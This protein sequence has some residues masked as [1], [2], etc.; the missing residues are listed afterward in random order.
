MTGDQSSDLAKIAREAKRDRK[1]LGI[2]GLGISPL[3]LTDEV[4]LSVSNSFSGAC[5]VVNDIDGTS[6]SCDTGRVILT[7]AADEPTLTVLSTDDST[8][9]TRGFSTSKG[10]KGSKYFKVKQK[11]GGHLETVDDTDEAFVPPKWSCEN[12]A[13]AAA[14]D[15]YLHDEKSQRRLVASGSGHS[16]LHRHHDR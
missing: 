11:K 12:E 4:E 2:K 5:R 13:A 8:G 15:S 1:R 9:E 16:H 3:G 10:H 7:S 6:T 14:H